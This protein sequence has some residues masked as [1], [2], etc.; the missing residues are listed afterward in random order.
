M[1]RFEKRGRKSTAFEDQTVVP[2]RK[3]RSVHQNQKA[4]VVWKRYVSTLFEFLIDE[5]FSPSG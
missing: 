4:L 3:F 1:T 2:G 5:K